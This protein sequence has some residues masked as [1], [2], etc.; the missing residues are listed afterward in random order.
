MR[1]RDL[2]R[3]RET[4][5]ANLEVYRRYSVTVKTHLQHIVDAASRAN[6]QALEAGEYIEQPV[7][8]AEKVIDDTKREM[9]ELAVKR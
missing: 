2:E 9:R 3:E 7:E 8:R 1:N 4:T 5:W 6:E